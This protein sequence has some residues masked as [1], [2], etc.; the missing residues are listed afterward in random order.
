VRRRQDAY[1]HGLSDLPSPAEWAQLKEAPE[2]DAYENPPGM[3]TSP[4]F[5]AGA[6]HGTHPDY[7]ADTPEECA[8]RWQEFVPDMPQMVS[9][10]IRDTF[11]VSPP[12][13]TPVDQ[14]M[15]P[16]SGVARDNL[17]QGVKKLLKTG[18]ARL[19]VRAKDGEPTFVTPVDAV[20]KKDGDFRIIHDWRVPNQERGIPDRRC[21]FEGLRHLPAVVTLGG[22]GASIDMK[23]GYFALFAGPADLMCFRARI[24][25]S[26]L[27]TLDREALDLPEGAGD[28]F[29]DVILTFAAL[30]MGNKLSAWVYTKTMRCVARRWRSLGIDCLWYLDDC[31]FFAPNAEKMRAIL[32]GGEY[33][34]QKF[35]GVVAD[36]AYLGIPINFEKSVLQPVRVLNWLGYTLDLTNGRIHVSKAKIAELLALLD[37]TDATVGSFVTARRLAKITGKLMS[38]S[39]ALQPVRLMSRE[40]YSLIRC[41]TKADWDATV[42]LSPGC[43]EELVFWARELVRWNAFGRKMLPDVT[44]CTVRIAGDAG[45]AGWGARGRRASCQDGQA[46]YKESFDAWSPEQ[47]EEDQSMRELLCLQEALVAFDKRGVDFS[48]RCV[49]AALESEE[50]IAALDLR[51]GEA[52]AALRG[53]VIGYDTDNMGVRAV[54]NRGG[55]RKLRFN[56]VVKGIW[57]WLLERGARLEVRWVT[58][59]HMCVVRGSGVSTDSLSRQRWADACDWTFRP[60]VIQE[61]RRWVSSWAS[62][63][64]LFTR[65]VVSG[66]VYARQWADD[67][68]PIV[69]PGG[70]HITAFIGFLRQAGRRACV[71]VPQWHGP[72]MSAVAQWAVDDRTLGPAYYVFRRPSRDDR[73]RQRRVPAWIMRAVVL[74]FRPDERRRG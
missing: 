51:P 29:V 1:L 64:C 32:H 66:G 15:R 40:T 23:S 10:W 26:W 49:R 8:A 2:P 38:C 30:S 57:R 73:G 12:D 39:L 6:I 17:D 3:R 31:V 46:A 44:P 60:A 14:P 43:V 19:W 67:D 72:A 22:V 71:V 41:K 33:E 74:D 34:G 70:N 55:S 68:M 48:D 59:L 47:A 63:L 42:A 61:L 21:R 25:P 5:V 50:A 13:R 37:D 62:P 52:A 65:D 16:S 24:R 18:S 45:P 28:D 35:N 36:C 54:I 20:P 56:A 53:E 9:T 4:P 27:S 58:G 11:L 69:F 7:G